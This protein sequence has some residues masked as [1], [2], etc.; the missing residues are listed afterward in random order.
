[1]TD[2]NAASPDGAPDTT[3]TATVWT[4]HPGTTWQWQLQ[5]TIDPSFDVVMYDIDLFDNTQSVIDSLHASGRKVI[6]YLSAGTYEPNRPD[7]SQFPASVRGTELP[8]WPGEYWLDTRS[9]IVRDI[10]KARM[11]LAVSKH[12]E[13]IEP[14]N[15]DGYTNNPGFPLTATTQLDYNH[16]LAS[17]AHARNLSVGLKND[18]DQIPDLVGA[19]D[20][21]LNEQCWQYSECDLYDPFLA[22]NKAIFNTE[23]GTASLATTVCPKANAKNLDTLIKMLDLGAWRV[24]CR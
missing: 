18:T 6:C 12:C 10:M 24:A 14:D 8:D 19:F 21:A 2:G 11:D 9:S 16:F 23:Y 3:T 20:W 17:E 7:S 5:G 15:V 1:M 22:A 13:G 4:P